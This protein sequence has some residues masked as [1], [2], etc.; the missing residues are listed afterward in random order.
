MNFLKLTQQL[1]DAAQEVAS[2]AG[3]MTEK[4]IE[5][6]SEIAKDWVEKAPDALESATD[7]LNR[8]VKGAAQQV[9]T[10]MDSSEAESK[11]KALDMTQ[12]PE[13]ERVAFYG[14]LFAI[15]DADG[16]IQKEE[17]DTIFGCM[18]LEGMSETARRT[19][20]GYVMSPPA[21]ETCLEALTD[22][23]ETLRFGLIVNAVHVARADDELDEDEGAAVHSIQERLDISD[24]Q[25]EAIAV[26]VKRLKEIESRGLDD[27]Y[28]ADAIKSAASGL[29]AV[30]V[31][32]AAVMFSGAVFGLS[33]AGITSGLAALGALVWVGGMVP[34][35][36][37][38]VLL[39]S[40]IY[41]GANRLLD[42]GGVRAKEKLRAEQTR[43]AQLVIENLQRAIE[44]LVERITNLEHKADNVESSALVI[45]ELKRRVKIL[46]Q[47]ANRR[48]QQ[49][50]AAS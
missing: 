42:T 8:V 50:E 28:A 38:A 44:V 46:M 2:K 43:K 15:A 11:S 30:G 16:F 5:Q 3:Q 23:D 40:G 25:L 19:T 27:N 34:G 9:V 48:K 20:L 18:N 17:V 1:Q 10:A 39:G 32:V 4:A 49:T 36:G 12:V 7:G 33:A 45:R 31:P 6:G 26:F 13:A 21:L 41:V 37:V 29:A 22:A 24:E 47:S 14:A 35:I